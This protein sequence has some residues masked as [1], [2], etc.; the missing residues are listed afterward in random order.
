MPLPRIAGASIRRA[1]HPL[2]DMRCSEPKE[3]HSLSQ[4]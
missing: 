3:P 4:L 2:G 1:V